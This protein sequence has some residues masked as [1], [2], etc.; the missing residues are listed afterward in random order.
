MRWAAFLTG[1]RGGVSNLVL[2]VAAARSVSPADHIPF[3]ASSSSVSIS[4]FFFYPPFSS[5]LS[6]RNRQFD[7]ALGF[8]SP[9]SLLGSA[10]L[11]AR[12]RSRLLGKISRV[13]G[14]EA[15]L[16]GSSKEMDSEAR[17]PMD[18]SSSPFPTS[19]DLGLRS[20]SAA[21]R[22]APKFR[23]PEHFSVWDFPLFFLVLLP[24]LSR[25]FTRGTP[26]S[27]PLPPNLLAATPRCRPQP[28]YEYSTV[29]PGAQQK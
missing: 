27:I 19:P 20:A 4:P 26:T 24:S 16:L 21:E 17:S 6:K 28:A 22:T 7:F 11:G 18:R 9:A 5:F 15:I 2:V 3:S 12:R 8:A 13:P 29:V 23:M 1:N 25:T 14:S 10:G